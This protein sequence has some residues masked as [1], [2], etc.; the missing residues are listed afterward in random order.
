MLLPGCRLSFQCWPGRPCRE[1]RLLRSGT[2]WR[3]EYFLK[4]KKKKI[5]RFHYSFKF[6]D[7]VQSF[8]ILFLY[9]CISLFVYFR[10]GCL[11][12]LSSLCL[13]VFFW[14]FSLESSGLFGC[15][16]LSHCFIFLS[17]SHV[18]FFLYV[19]LLYLSF[20][21]S[22]FFSFFLP[23][24]FCFQCFV[25][26]SICFSVFVSLYLSVFLCFVPS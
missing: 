10:L 3:A 17:L 2:R 14:S 6:I 1:R 20:C 26:M 22:V 19:S 12:G 21:C 11:Y 16:F 9:L 7:F 18:S 24:S 4:I 13:S 25:F 5:I 15:L 8:F 23:L